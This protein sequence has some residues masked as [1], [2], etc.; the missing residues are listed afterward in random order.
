M[1]PIDYSKWDNIDTDSEPEDAQQQPPLLRGNPP[2]DASIPHKTAS[3]GLE[4]MD[5]AFELREPKHESGCTELS[6]CT[7]WSASCHSYGFA[8][9]L[10]E[11]SAYHGN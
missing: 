10:S 4:C 6:I 9:A 5:L 7:I 1:A 11:A 2:A 8:T 3:A